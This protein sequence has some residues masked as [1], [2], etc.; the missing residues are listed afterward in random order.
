M[1]FSYFIFS[2]VLIQVII[3]VIRKL[4]EAVTVGYQDTVLVLQMWF[5]V[6]ILFQN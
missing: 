6:L 2:F 4:S 5:G 1:M 3:T